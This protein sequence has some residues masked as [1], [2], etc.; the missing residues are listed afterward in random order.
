MEGG[1]TPGPVKIA[2]LQINPTDGDLAAAGAA[3]GV[4]LAVEPRWQTAIPTI[5]AASLCVAGIAAHLRTV[6]DAAAL[7]ARRV[8][9]LA[10]PAAIAVATDPVHAVPQGTIST[11]LAGL[12]KV[13]AR[14][15]ALAVARAKLPL[16]A[17]LRAAH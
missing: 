2:L 16:R 15:D 7:L 10:S 6:G 9:L 11:A 5:E 1:R 17:R 12:P 8:A 4:V 3:I 14:S 13:G